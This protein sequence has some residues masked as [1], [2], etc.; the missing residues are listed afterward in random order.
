M[1]TRHPII[2][3][4]K[5][6]YKKLKEQQERMRKEIGKAPTI[7]ELIEIKMRGRATIEIRGLSKKRMRI[8]W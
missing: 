6:V 2:R 7:S 5:S 3:L 8:I 4:R 1:T